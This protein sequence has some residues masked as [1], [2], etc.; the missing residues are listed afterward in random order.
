M[1][2]GLATQ[3][4]KACR[5]LSVAHELAGQSHVEAAWLEAALP[6]E[7]IE[8]LRF[9]KMPTTTHRRFKLRMGHASRMGGAPNSWSVWLGPEDPG[10]REQAG[11]GGGGGVGD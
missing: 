3:G 10:C 1:V 7:A 9:E 4:Y 5:L 8:R 11:Q 2:A 6:S